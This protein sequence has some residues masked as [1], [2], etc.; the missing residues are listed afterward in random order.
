MFPPFF[1]SRYASL[2]LTPLILAYSHTLF[3]WAPQR[4]Q[5]Y[6]SVSVLRLR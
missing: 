4:L 5:R 3:P 6:W 1:N 2:L